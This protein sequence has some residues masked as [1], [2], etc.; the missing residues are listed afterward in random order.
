MTQP[1]SEITALLARQANWRTPQVTKPR[2]PWWKHPWAVCWVLVAVSAVGLALAMVFEPDPILYQNQPFPVD[3]PVRAGEPIPIHVT[4][5][6][7]TGEVGDFSYTR[8]LRSRDGGMNYQLV[9]GTA[10]NLEG[11]P[12][13][14]LSLG[15]LAPPQMVPGHYELIG[16]VH[17]NGR[18]RD[19]KIIYHS[20]VFEVVR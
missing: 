6:N 18:F 14:S 7:T 17:V 5:C 16:V 19:H 9:D 10:V 2:Y 15:L 20:E 8:V 3:G 4:R 12:T 13:S 11:C 1:P